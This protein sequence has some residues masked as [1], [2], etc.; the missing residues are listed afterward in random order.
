MT[1]Q[2]VITTKP[3]APKWA[4][5]IKNELWRFPC[6]NAIRRLISAIVGAP[7]SKFPKDVDTSPKYSLH[8][9]ALPLSSPSRWNRSK[10]ESMRPENNSTAKIAIRAQTRATMRN[11]KN[12]GR[13]SKTRYATNTK[14]NSKMLIATPA[15]PTLYKHAGT[16]SRA[17]RRL[18]LRSCLQR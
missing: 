2:T 3:I 5:S 10:R 6:W 11:F 13:S 18:I 8:I 12:A 7:S 14:A 15:R 17:G 16:A 1:E 4:W 9:F